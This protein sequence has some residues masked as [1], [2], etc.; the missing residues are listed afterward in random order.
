[1]SLSISSFRLIASWLASAQWV[2]PYS[3]L[4]NNCYFDKMIN[5]DDTVIF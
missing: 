1:M 5:R 2:S 3:D 4:T